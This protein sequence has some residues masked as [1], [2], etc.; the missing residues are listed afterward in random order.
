[1]KMVGGVYSGIGTKI[2]IHLE[3]TLSLFKSKEGPENNR[4]INK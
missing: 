2:I 1:M 3:V 4:K